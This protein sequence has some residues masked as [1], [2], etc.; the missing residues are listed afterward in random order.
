MNFIDKVV[1]KDKEPTVHMH[2]HTHTPGEK[3]D[4]IEHMKESF[5]DLKINSFNLL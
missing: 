2:H 1:K 5:Q 3:H 4:E